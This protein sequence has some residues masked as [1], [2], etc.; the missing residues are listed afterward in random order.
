MLGMDVNDGTRYEREPDRASVFKELCIA[1][2]I[3]SG[4]SPALPLGEG[5][6]TML[7]SLK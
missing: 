4:S 6:V 3:T 2:E 1:T 5:S 7:Q